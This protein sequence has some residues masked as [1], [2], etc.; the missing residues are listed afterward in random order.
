MNNLIK[1]I[2]S[3][4]SNICFYTTNDINQKTNCIN[5][6][7]T[8]DLYKNKT[9]YEIMSAD[10]LKNN[11]ELFYSFIKEK[12]NLTELIP[13]NIHK[14]I[15]HC[16]NDHNISV[17]TENIDSLHFQAGAINV[18][19]L[20]GSIKKCYCPSCL[21][22]HPFGNLIYNNIL[23]KCSCGGLIRPDCLLVGEN[24]DGN[25]L[26]NAFFTLKSADKIIIMGKSNFLKIYNQLFK[27]IDDNKIV[28]IK[29][30]ELL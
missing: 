28:H 25:A 21:E 7:S 19:E 16:Q 17:I 20:F 9:Y 23:P 13:Y 5:F 24:I 14:F 4:Y 15:A 26:I 3:N 27:D 10:T 6:Y 11:P 1:Q 22:E 29:I 2:L 30:D 18:I 8:K 12:G